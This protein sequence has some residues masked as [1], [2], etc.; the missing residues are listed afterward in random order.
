MA[1]QNKGFSIT[2]R[3]SILFLLLIFVLL[4]TW[5][6]V[7]Y[8]CSCFFVKTIEIYNLIPENN[9]SDQ[10]E[11]R[12]KDFLFSKNFF[13]PNYNFLFLPIKELKNEFQNIFL[14][15]NIEIQRNLSQR[16]IKIFLEPQD[17]IFYLF[18][19]GL[20]YAVDENANILSLTQNFD[21]WHP[22]IIIAN[23]SIAENFLKEKKFKL[24]IIEFLKKFYS[25][26]NETYDKLGN[27]KQSTWWFYN[28]D[29]SLALKVSDPKIKIFF[30][31][32]DDPELQLKKLEYFLNDILNPE[33]LKKID[34]IDLRFKDRV[35]YRFQ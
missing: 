21:T 3:L 11:E 8:L 25:L 24:E 12:L 33:E 22:K 1:S 16:K 10:F 17:S 20:I 4:Y 32:F 9:I 18:N 23:P 30:N 27:I 19:Q 5:F 7:F 14:T 13:G 31:Y 15:K 29:E 26:T 35:Y 2:R 28:P 6:F 34:Y